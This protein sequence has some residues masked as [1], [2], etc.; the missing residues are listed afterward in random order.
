MDTL[1]FLQTIL[2]ETGIKY[3]A[4]FKQ[5]LPYP[6]HKSYESLETMAEAVANFN[7]DPEYTA[8]YHACGSYLAPF[9][10]VDRD[11]KT[12]RSHHRRRDTQENQEL[13]DTQRPW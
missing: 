6:L 12:K 9:V 7:R 11:G 2:P 5:G 4:L 10:P 8:V 13:A 1:T 3:L